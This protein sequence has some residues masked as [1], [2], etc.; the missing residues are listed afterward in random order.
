M[1]LI[2]IAAC[3][4]SSPSPSSPPASGGGGGGGGGTTITAT[5]T[6]F[7][8]TLSADSAA[9][10]SLTFVA[11][12]KGSIQHEL[13]LVKTDDDPGSLPMA[14]DGSTAD[15]TASGVTKVG[16][17]DA[18]DPGTTKSFT[19]TLQPGKY[20]LLCNVPAHYATGMHVGF[21]VTGS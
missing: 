16:G 2:L 13:I 21:T 9:A 1:A 11:D 6:E 3:G 18:V 12:N 7:K 10:G 14:S 5:E 8:I 15:L 17:V 4:S 19:V 20:V